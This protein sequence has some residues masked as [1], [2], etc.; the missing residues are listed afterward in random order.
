MADD[1][2]SSN[3]NEQPTDSGKPGF[4]RRKFLGTL[5]AGAAA[6]GLGIGPG[7]GPAAARVR[8][9]LSAAAAGRRV[10]VFGGGMGGLTVAHELAERGY[11]VTVYEPKAWGG[12][13]RSM[14][15]P[16]TGTGGRQDLPGE[17]GFRFFPGFYQ[18]LPDTMSRIPRPGGG[19]ARDNLVA[20][21][22]EVAYYRGIVI[23]LPAEGSIVGTLS[24]QSL[25]TF[26]QTAL[27]VGTMVPANEIAY[28]L[29]KI[30]AFVTSGPRR[31]LG[32]WEKMSFADFVKSSRMSPTYREL[33]V[34]M[35]T[36][37][38]V[39]AKPDKANARTMGLMAEGWAYS[40]LGLGG[41]RAP[42]QVL[43]A[44]TNEALIDPWLAYLRSLG[45]NFQMG[46]RLTE[47]QVANRQI[48]GA[49]VS[50]AG[51]TSTVDADHYVLAVPVERAIPLLN[52]DILAIDPG[53]AGLRGLTTDWMNGVMLYL[54]R[55][56]RLSNGHVT[57]PG[58]PWALTSISQ[59]QFW[60]NRFA[61]AY[62]DGTV[63]DC[64]SL[65]LSAWDKPGVLY[66]KPA[67]ECTPAQI[68]NEIKEQLR[69]S[70]PL[71]PL[72]LPDSNI[73]SYFI[74]PAI[75]G[76]ATPGVADD[77]PLLINTPDSWSL[78]PEAITAL[79]NLYLASDYVRCD[80]NLATME[81]ANEAGR[82]AANA[83][84]DNSGGSEPHARL[85]KLFRP[86]EFAPIYADDDLR[87]SLGLPNAYDVIDPHWP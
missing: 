22:E 70:I 17:H 41:Y 56:L 43:N 62:G 52:N 7:G 55:P 4:D 31:R 46:A 8:S 21:R 32:Q 59:G 79:P 3:T 20:G 13:C 15:V 74:D 38:L 37:T 58:Q 2:H 82:K 68:I 69:R 39:A 1:V 75:T 76:L 57:F 67:K 18:N 87:Y 80:I 33:L 63:Q 73:H 12:K 11:Q 14:P 84:I 42:D 66:G 54:K 16:G 28:F 6:T 24:P 35:F 51:G 77:E 5:A 29:Q 45:V 83:V 23:R 65:D 34:D 9:A 49:R 81:G 19:T 71:G 48:S 64:L 85:F 36:S 25:L 10:A 30:I 50:T 61:D 72:A 44:P 26:L 27:Q 60:R 53:L 78:R 47:L 86:N 40:T